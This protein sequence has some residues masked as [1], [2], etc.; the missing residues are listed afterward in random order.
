MRAALAA[1]AV[2][3]LVG[4]DAP[5][6]VPWTGIG[7][8]RLGMNRVAVDASYGRPSA[9]ERI[10]LQAG[11]RY[12]R[13]TVLDAT[14]AVPHGTIVVRYVDGVARAATTTSPRYR[15]PTGIRVGLV[16]PRTTR[17]RGFI[18]LDCTRA[19]YLERGSTVI[20]LFLDRDPVVQRSRPR[21]TAI[22]F[23]ASDALLPC[24]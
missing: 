23:G 4:A 1:L 9:T 11:T 24:F 2:A 14:Y 13:R 6:I 15:T 8:I 18:F 21:I 20:Q 17:W 3:G 12:W 22:Q 10:H 16:T 7:S 5:T 19:W